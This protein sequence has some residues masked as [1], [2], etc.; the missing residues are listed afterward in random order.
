MRPSAR[1]L[2]DTVLTTPM[3]PASWA[4]T[5]CR[6][7]NAPTNKPMT[8]PAAPHPA[9]VAGAHHRAPSSR[10]RTTIHGI[11]PSPAPNVL[12][13]AIVAGPY[14]RIPSVTEGARVIATSPPD[15][16]SLPA[17]APETA[18]PIALAR[19]QAATN[20]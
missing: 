17:N 13:A 16:A 20:L 19:T 11:A 9:T 12:I 10:P 15:A 18:T 5:V 6:P 14:W 3:S 1:R 8:A 2:S 4:P 7:F